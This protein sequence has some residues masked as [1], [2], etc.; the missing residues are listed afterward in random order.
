MSKG[1][2]TEALPVQDLMEQFLGQRLDVMCEVD[3]TQA[4]TAAKKG[5]SKKL[6]ALPRTHRVSL[7]VVHECV[8]DPRMQV[9]VEYCPTDVMKGDMFTKAL[10]PGPILLVREFCGS[11]PD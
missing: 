6:R 4:I 1:L 5:Y 11:L 10:L 8:S 2:R 7:G 3:N 9:G